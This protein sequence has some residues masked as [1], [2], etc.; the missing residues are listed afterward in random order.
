MTA[1]DRLFI[2]GEWVAPAGSSARIEV[3]SPYD[4]SLTGSVPSAVEE[5]IDRAVAAAREAFDT[6]PWPHSSPLERQVVLARF[7][8]LYAA[9]AQEFAALITRENGSPIQFTAMIGAV[10]GLQSQAYLAAAKDFAWET[11]QPAFPQGEVICRRVPVGVVAAVVPWNAPHQSALVK[12]F[13]AL[14]A[15]CTAILKV[16]PETAL[17]GQVLG[18]LFMEAGLPRGVLSI[19]AADRAVSEYLVGHPGVD[20]IAFTG[21]TA[22]GRQIAAIAGAQLKRI[23]L[24]LGGKSPAIVLPGADQQAVIGAVCAGSLAN[25][26]QTCVAQTRILVPRGEHHAFAARLAAKIAA[27]R[28]GDPSDPATDIGPLVSERQR[29]RVADYIDIGIAENATVAT[30]GPGMPDGIDGGAFVRPTVFANVDNG[31][32]IAREEI[33]G[34]VLCV[35]PYDTVEDAVRIANDS[36]YGLAGGVWSAQPQEAIGV[37]RSLRTGNVSINGGFAGFGAP[38][39][40]FKQSGVGREFGGE[41]ISAYTEWQSIGV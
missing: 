39:G 34:P 33:F 41:G 36:A 35:I 20:K 31:M 24:E 9:R 32:R 26:G 12:L 10:V 25:S 17:D 23:S 22:A 2:G 21:S 15:G 29:Q 13:P 30:G 3:R 37:G 1:Y 11:R 18:D 8:E 28:I 38:F 5:D 27:M 19:V 4:G 16:A 40:G 6:G 14:L 7:V